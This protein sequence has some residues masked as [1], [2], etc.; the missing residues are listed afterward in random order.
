[1]QKNTGP[2][3]TES[4]KE[5]VPVKILCL[6]IQRET[7]G[8]QRRERRGDGPRGILPKA[9]RRFERSHPTGFEQFIRHFP[10]LP[11]SVN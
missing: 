7:V 10:N 8:Q 1:M 11:L 4:Q 2:F 5:H 6:N 9:G 3:R